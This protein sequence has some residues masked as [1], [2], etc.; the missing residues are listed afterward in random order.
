MN[1]FMTATAIDSD[2]IAMSSELEASEMEGLYGSTHPTETI[3][4]LL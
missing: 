3:D 1:N 2:E 4:Y